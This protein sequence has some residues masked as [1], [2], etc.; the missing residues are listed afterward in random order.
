MTKKLYETDSYIKAFDAKVLSCD[1]KDGYYYIVLDQTAFFAEGGGQAADTGFIN[2]ASVLDVQLENDTVVHK[3]DKPLVV[4]ESVTCELDWELRF[5]RMQSHAGEHIVSGIINSMFGFNNVGFHMSDSTVVMDV[6]GA[7]TQ[8]DIEQVELEAN[9]AVYLNK[10]IYAHYPT[11]EE[12]KTV[13]YRSKLDFD[14]GVRLITIEDY[15]CCACCAPHPSRTGEIGVIKVIDF[16]P[17]RSGTRIELVCGI[18]AFKDYCALH[19]SNKAIMNLLSAPRDQVYDLALKEHESLTAARNENKAL[20]ERLT[21]AELEKLEIGNSVCAFA[22]GASYDALRY[23]ANALN[24]D[25]IDYCCIFS[26][27]GSGD[28]SYV[29][30]STSQNIQPFIKELHAAF[31]GKGGGKPNYAQGKI[32]AAKSELIS[33]VERLVRS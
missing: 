24:S 12:L 18:N 30:S 1:H 8:A 7:L 17:N 27:M 20:S 33:F 6:D 21:F 14:E 2:D 26:N 9:R 32:T 29:I 11:A 13:K 10:A 28:Y 22:S 5:E 31:N 23:C 19:N 4:G 16:Y 15:D 3:T 25:E